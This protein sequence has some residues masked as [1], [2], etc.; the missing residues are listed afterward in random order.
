MIDPAKPA[1][2]Q[3]GSSDR[4]G[5][6]ALQGDEALLFDRYQDRLRRVTSAT[7]VTSPDN[8]DDACA[9]AWSQLLARQPKREW[10]FAW[11]R[12]VA[13]REALRLDKVGRATSVLDDTENASGLGAARVR[14]PATAHRSA[15]ST[16]ALLE[17]RERLALLPA[18]QREIAFMRAAGWRYGDIAECLGI[19]EA[20][21]NKLL[22]RGDARLRELDRRDIAP[23]SEDDP[24][25][26]LLSTIGRP[27]RADPKRAGEH[28]RLEWRRLA[29]AVDDLRV[30]HGISDP[31]R[32]FGGEKS[33]AIPVADRNG[34]EQ[35]IASFAHARGRGADRT[36]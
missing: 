27:P 10:I 25:P 2:E 36:L 19:T 31:R 28:L 14:S 16:H 32:A 3:A 35:R 24:P 12:L 23:R 1:P 17:V 13:R 4:G 21:V 20:R 34:L 30:A 33:E 8:V 6:A 7:V 18:D 9:F 15:E 29:L 5:P 11:L 26:F 22:V